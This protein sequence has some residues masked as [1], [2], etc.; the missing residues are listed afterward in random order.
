MILD[1]DGHTEEPRR[2]NLVR[3]VLAV[4]NFFRLCVLEL[5]LELVQRN[6]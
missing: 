6:V 3:W 5:T 1:L 2:A 4:P